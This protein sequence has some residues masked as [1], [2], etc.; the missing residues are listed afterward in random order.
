MT[1][2]RIEETSAE[3]H[4]CYC[5]A[6]E[7]RFGKP[8]WTNGDYSKLDEPTKDYDREMAK[9]HL[10]HIDTLKKEN[11]RLD[12]LAVMEGEPGHEHYWKDEAVAL[13][14]E[15]DRL[16]AEVERLNSLLSGYRKELG[17]LTAT[18]DRYRKIIST[19]VSYGHG[20]ADELQRFTDSEE[21][22]TWLGYENVAKQALKQT[23]GV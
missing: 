22:L 2:Q 17:T 11:E 16:T 23:E 4:K 19:L 9:W 10:Q 15:I 12:S 14:P 3:I 21:V 1:D 20:L 18:V 5:R 6:Y 8:Y 13:Y 7:R